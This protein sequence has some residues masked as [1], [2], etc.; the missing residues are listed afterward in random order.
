[1]VRYY[2]AGQKKPKKPDSCENCNPEFILAQGHVL[3]EG[4]EIFKQKVKK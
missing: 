3:C 2:R 4:C 1:M